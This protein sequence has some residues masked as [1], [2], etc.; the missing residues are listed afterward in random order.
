MTTKEDFQLH[1]KTLYSW[2]ES[3]DREEQ[4]PI[5]EEAV[6]RLIVERFTGQVVDVDLELTAT[7][8]RNLIQEK[9]RE[10]KYYKEQ[11]RSVFRNDRNNLETTFY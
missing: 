10:I 8:L 9:L 11:P 7:S 5:C 1:E 3:C 6:K 2:I 4:I